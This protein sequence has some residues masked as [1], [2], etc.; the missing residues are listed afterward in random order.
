VFAPYLS[1]TVDSNM[2]KGCSVALAAYGSQLSGQ[3]PTFSDNNLN[4][5]GA[6]TTDPNGTYG[7][8]PTTD[9]LGFGFGDL[10]GT[11][12]GNSF[13]HFG[14]GTFVTQASGGVATVT[15]H[16]NSFHNNGT[17]ANGDT[18]TSVNAV[19]NWWGCKQGPNMGGDCD[20]AIRTVQ[21]RP[22][23]TKKP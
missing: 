12:T 4:G 11:L 7:A 21:F 1:A 15:A 8:Y 3:G 10:T 2:I 14:T 23:L 16:N 22:W 9:L 19:N 5:C 20:T 6:K 13:E 18:G 17:G